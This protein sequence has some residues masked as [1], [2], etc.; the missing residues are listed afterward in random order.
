MIEIRSATFE[1]KESLRQIYSAA[2]GS[3][4]ALDETTANR[5]IGVG[6]VVVALLEG[7]VVGFGA[8]DIDATEQLKWLYLLPEH[9]GVG[10][11][12]K[13]LASMEVIGV[14]AGLPSL[15]IHA[16]RDAVAFYRKH[17]YTEVKQSESL[18]HDHAGL[19][20]TKQL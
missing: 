16:A 10:L 13:L 9:Q 1:D 8:I 6:G 3:D 15:R 4:V 5:L 17:G 12:G 20:M 18:H 7:R 2:V 19:E 14:K 11:G